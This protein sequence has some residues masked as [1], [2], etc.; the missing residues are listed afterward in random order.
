MTRGHDMGGSCVEIGRSNE[1]QQLAIV[2]TQSEAIDLLDAGADD[3]EQYATRRLCL[4]CRCT[5]APDDSQ[6]QRHSARAQKLQPRSSFRRWAKAG[7]ICF[8]SPTT[9]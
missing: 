1:V 3:V 7:T 6:Q 5:T 2:R 9:P 4:H 8:Q